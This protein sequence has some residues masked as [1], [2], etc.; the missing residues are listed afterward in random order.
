MERVLLSRKRLKAPTELKVKDTPLLCDRGRRTRTIKL[1]YFPG[2]FLFSSRT[3]FFQISFRDTATYYLF[4]LLGLLFPFF[5]DWNCSTFFFSS[6]PIGMCNVIR[7][8]W[9]R[10]AFSFS[11]LLLHASHSCPN[12]SILLRPP[13]LPCHSLLI[14][15]PSF[16][17][18]CKFRPSFPF[19]ALGLVFIL[20]FSACFSHPP[21]SVSPSNPHP[22]TLFQ[23]CLSSRSIH[24]HPNPFSKH[25]FPALF[26]V[27]LRM[28]DI[29]FCA[30]SRFWLQVP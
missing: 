23:A 12:L 29:V 7:L 30:F 21:H 2:S 9:L 14:T 3:L 18:N 11:S 5:S 15:P 16:P 25:V 13:L 19:C 28:I 20:R 27:G 24:S 1:W 10:F 4:P 26:L 8:C 22:D 6:F 17:R